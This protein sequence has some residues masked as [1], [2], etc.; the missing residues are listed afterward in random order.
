MI[1]LSAAI[2]EGEQNSSALASVEAREV[3]NFILQMQKQFTDA[4]LRRCHDCPGVCW[5][6]ETTMKFWKLWNARAE[7]DAQVAPASKWD[8]IDGKNW[9]GMVSDMIATMANW[10]PT[11]RNPL[12]TLSELRAESARLRDIGNILMPPAAA[13]TPEHTETPSETV[14]NECDGM[15]VY[16]WDGEEQECAFCDG[17]GRV[18]SSASEETPK[19]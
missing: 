13:A 18:K 19:P 17:T 7:I 6:D 5:Q 4:D 14:C 12:D 11:S 8:T 10:S 2:V 3:E 1:N 16:E 9:L 15:G